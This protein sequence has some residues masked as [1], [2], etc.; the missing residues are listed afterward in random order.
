MTPTP[1]ARTMPRHRI[2]RREHLPYDGFSP[3]FCERCGHQITHL[4]EVTDTQTDAVIWPLG[5]DCVYKVIGITPA[6]ASAA[7][8]EYEAEVASDE[9]LLERVRKSREWQIVNADILAGLERLA[10]GSEHYL[11]N[12]ESMLE[13]VQKWGTL[14]EKQLE[15]ATRMIENIGRYCNREAYYETVHLAYFLQCELRLGRYDSQF[16]NDIT[17]R[18]QF[19]VTTKQAEAVCKIAYKYRRQISEKPKAA[20]DWHI[21]LQ[22]VAS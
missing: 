22:A 5:S 19:G 3:V 14:T 2:T 6:A 9:E 10:D 4:Y 12:A 15:Y 21:T 16:L 13:N 18:D 1:A 20:A 17:S 7:W 8:N 11:P